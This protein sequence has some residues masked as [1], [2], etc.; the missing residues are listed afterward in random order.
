MGGCCVGRMVEAPCERPL[1]GRFFCTTTTGGRIASRAR[2]LFG[3]CLTLS[4]RYGMDP[5]RDRLS[6]DA[7]KSDG[8][9]EFERRVAELKRRM[10][11]GEMLTE[12]QERSSPRELR[13]HPVVDE[14]EKIL[15][16]TRPRMTQAERDNLQRIKLRTHQVGSQVLADH[17]QPIPGNDPDRPN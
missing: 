11:S 16:E 17:G 2:S 4:Y 7:G 1:V 5:G 12:A 9:L 15:A 3:W 6:G 13:S 8:M 14:Y 10:E